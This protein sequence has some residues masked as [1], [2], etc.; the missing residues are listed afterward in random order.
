MSLA[1]AN[2]VNQDK[3]KNL[4]RE[5]MLLL[6]P[7]ISYMDGRTKQAFRDEADINKIMARADKAGTISHLEKY[8]GVYADYSDFDFQTQTMRLAQGQTI[9]DELPAEIRREFGQSPHDFF[10]YVNDPKNIDDLR[11][12]LPGLAAPGQQRMS[13]MPPDADKEKAD[14]AVNEPLASKK[15]KEEQASPELQKVLQEATE[16]FHAD[17]KADDT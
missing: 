9:F 12:R 15:P 8:E 16:A 14:K 3:R 13:V 10:E 11:T 6:L 5:E 4:S 17:K 2:L 1:L 7:E